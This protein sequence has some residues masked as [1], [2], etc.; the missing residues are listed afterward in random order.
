M[1][2]CSKCGT[3]LMEGAK[4]CPK[5]GNPTGSSETKEMAEENSANYCLELVS[6]GFA[7]LQVVKALREI[8]D[9]GLKEAKD[10]VDST[11][12]EIAE[13][14]T[15]TKAKE[16]ASLLS[17]VGAKTIIKQNGKTIF[18]EEPSQNVN[19][20]TEEQGGN[21]LIKYGTYVFA[22][23]CFFYIIGT[24]EGGSSDG[25]EE[26]QIEQKQESPAEKQAREKKEQADREANEKQEKI[27]RVAEIAYK[28]GYDTRKATWGETIAS[29]DAAAADYR[30]RYAVDPEDAGQ[31]ERWNVFR[32]NYQKGFSD[33]ADEI[34]NKFRKEDF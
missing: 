11:P 17:T 12:L 26:T 5:C 22:A 28:M 33:A 30:Y 10:M 4:F 20:Q 6:A 16:I 31:S 23:L 8:L 29:E 1:A 21:K 7:K 18:I 34:I 25:Q 9:I 3:E 19:P 24:C 15:L 14:L 2:F 32:E 27:K 13:G